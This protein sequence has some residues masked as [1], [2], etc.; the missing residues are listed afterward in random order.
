MD[1]LSFSADGISAT[2][3]GKPSSGHA[4]SLY[5][6]LPIE[7]GL[8]ATVGFRRGL[9]QNLCCCWSNKHAMTRGAVEVPLSLYGTIILPTI[10]IQDDSYPST[11]GELR[12]ANEVYGR[13]LPILELDGLPDLEVGELSHC[14]DRSWFFVCVRDCLG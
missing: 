3:L 4:L 1:A 14:C 10:V 13:R 2:F 5:C 9:V 8:C 12:L 11:C 6:R 7:L